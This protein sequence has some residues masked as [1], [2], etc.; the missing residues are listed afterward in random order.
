MP[1]SAG[2]TLAHCAV[3]GDYRVIPA[4]PRR[5]PATRPFP[6][7]AGRIIYGFDLDQAGL[8]RTVR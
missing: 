5:R 2:W 7:R 4:S 1:A 8:A 6:N 3:A